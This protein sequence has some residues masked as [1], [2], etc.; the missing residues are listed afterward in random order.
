MAA[1]LLVFF[2]SCV[3]WTVRPINEQKEPGTGPAAGTPE[4]FVNSIWAAKFVPAVMSAAVEARTLLDALQA[5]PEDAIARFGRREAGGPA[6]FIVRGQGE[7][8]KV[9]T[10]SRV[11]LALVDVPPFDKRPDLSIQIGPLLRGSSL[12]D[13]S[14][15]VRFSDFVNQIQFADVGNQLNERVAESVLAPIDKNALVGR[16]IRFTGTLAAEDG[17]E[18]PL[19]ELAPVELVVVEK[20]K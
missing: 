16:L 18:P 3:P 9:D 11:G 8:V 5:S 2:T 14:G 10:N 15:L 13:A 20:A 19:R 7:V 17:V 6:Y 1:M 12:R 4:E